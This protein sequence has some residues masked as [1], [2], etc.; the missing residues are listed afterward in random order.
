MQDIGNDVVIGKIFWNKGLKRNFL[1]LDGRVGG[2]IA[3]KPRAN[4]THHR[5]NL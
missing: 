2:Q 5:S 3:R 4:M 1:R